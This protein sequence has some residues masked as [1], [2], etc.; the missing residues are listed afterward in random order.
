M[1]NI[2]GVFLNK[3]G[4]TVLPHVMVSINCIRINENTKHGIK[5]IVHATT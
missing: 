1:L 4:H 5:N 3:F 2:F